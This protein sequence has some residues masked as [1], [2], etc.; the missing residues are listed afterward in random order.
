MT[1]SEN[2]PLVGAHIS[3]SGGF[4]KAVEH[5]E[6]SFCK[7]IQIFTKNSNQW[8]AK[9]ITNADIEKF[10]QARSKS[11]IRAFIGH[12]GYLINL[13]S[14]REDIYRK[15]LESIKEE[16]NR[17][18]LL[19]LSDLVMH[20]G[21]HLEKGEDYAIK[22]IA[23]SLNRIIDETPDIKTRFS[24]E[25]TAGQGTSVGHRFEQIANII[26]IVE[27][28]KRLSVCFDTCHVFA[29]G[30]DI[31]EIQGWERTICEFSDIIGLDHLK[32]FHVN[33]SKKPFG[34][35]VDRHEQLGIGE[36]G[37][38][39][40]EFLMQDKRFIDIPKILETPKGDDP[41]TN[42]IRNLD[43]LRGFVK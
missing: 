33:D 39:P 7:A 21:A 23:D 40:F 28:K 8:K 15:S 9:P 37:L 36:L 4:H 10:V 13:C 31:R 20:P 2:D 27:N 41:V 30:Y 11:N 12:V 24:L 19:G 29:A 34:S 25:T 5:A 17:A 42:D 22:K 1:V 3:I 26:K 6:I 38:K 35:R 43:I 14:P 18:H 16:I 32:V